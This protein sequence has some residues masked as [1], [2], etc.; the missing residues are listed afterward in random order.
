MDEKFILSCHIR[1]GC[2]FDS[3]EFESD[4]NSTEINDLIGTT[5]P[6]KNF[7]YF[8]YVCKQAISIL[9][10]GISRKSYV[11]IAG[12]PSVKELVGFYFISWN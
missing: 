1:H 9:P 2:F 12:K 6:G 5:G 10:T 3:V 4:G 11:S 7:Y 8:I